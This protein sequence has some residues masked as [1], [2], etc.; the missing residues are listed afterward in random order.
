MDALGT[1][2]IHRGVVVCLRRCGYTCL[3]PATRNLATV[4]VGIVQ[5]NEAPSLARP[6]IFPGYSLAYPPEMAM[7][8]RLAQAGAELVVWPETRYKGYFDQPHVQNARSEERR[9]G[10][11]CV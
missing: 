5:P 4:T 7:T 2:I 3:G 9:V 1:V 11:E 8:E 10:K 6:A